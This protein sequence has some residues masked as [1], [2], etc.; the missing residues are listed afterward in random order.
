MRNAEWKIAL[1]ALL[2][3]MLAGAVAAAEK[4]FINRLFF[5]DFIT[6]GRTIGENP[7]QSSIIAGSTL[8][9]GWIIYANDRRIADEMKINRG[10][11]LS[12]T[13][14][15]A[16]YGGD[17]I[18]VAA[19]D[20]LLFLG[21]ARE[22]KAA[23]LTLESILVSG[24]ILYV[25][26]TALGRMRPWDSQDPYMFRPFSFS[27]M[28]MPS[29][30]AAVAF[31]WAT[32]LGDTYDIGYIT[33]PLAALV[34]WARVYKSAHWPSDVLIGGVLGCV[35]AKILNSEPADETTGF[36]AIQMR[37]ADSGTPM[38]CLNLKI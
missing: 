10:S 3:L 23:R 35:T 20:S 9:A 4:P 12:T 25:F 32:I 7:V 8:L 18:Y 17:G 36:A 24:A 16:N 26:K 30:H 14:D 2:F 27:N 38:L 29:G 31:S 6:I 13:L 34:A 11:F 33:Y 22:K 15:I 19:A 1:I 21:G 5:D 28:S 37:M